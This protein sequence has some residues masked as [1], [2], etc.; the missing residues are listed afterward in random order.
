M[1][2]G[3]GG[4]V[5]TVGVI[6][7]GDAAKAIVWDYDP[8]TI[9]QG[10]NDT[11]AMLGLLEPHIVVRRV[12]LAP[13]YFRQ[14]RRYDFRKFDLVWNSISDEVQNSKILAI[15][16]KLATEAK[17]P[18]INPPVLIPRTSRA[19]TAKRLAGIEGVVVP[20]VLV[21]RNP[22]RERVA[23]QIDEAGFGFPAILRRTGTHNGEVIGLFDDLDS[24]ETIFGDRKHEYNLIEFVDV[25]P[26]DGLYRK[27]R[28]FFVGDQVITRQ[29][30]VSDEWSVH[31]KSSRR[32]MSSRDDLLVE[33]RA[34][35]TDGFEALPEQ[36]RTRV[37]AIR[38]RMGLDYLGLDCCLLQSGDIVVFECNATMNFNP[39]FRN[40]AM[41]HNRA[42]LP[43]YLEALR[44]LVMARSR[45]RAT[46]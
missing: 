30:I 44:A 35:L 34:M 46:A 15:A 23:R 38:E 21:L 13:S 17:L 29:H 18:I 39:A 3:S 45:T 43:R 7:G 10:N 2:G 31:G 12:F 4:M 25:R 16:Q 26:G 40:P 6:C 33:S 11:L 28:F 36:V 8:N 9:V 22:S 27:T 32:I 42:S 37:H 14:P 20:K 19:E 41:Q 1:T 5:P 24:L